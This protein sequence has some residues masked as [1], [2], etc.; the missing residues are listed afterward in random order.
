MGIY[1]LPAIIDY[2]ISYK[3]EETIF[4]VGHSMG[5]TMFYVMASERPD[6]AR[7]IRA[8]FSLAPVAFLNH[9]KS[10]IRILAPYVRDIEVRN[11]TRLF[12]YT[13]LYLTIL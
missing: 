7:K 11:Y 13:F 8:M 10:P 3:N 6:I 4:Y 12:T 1:D 2:I 9:V 5:T